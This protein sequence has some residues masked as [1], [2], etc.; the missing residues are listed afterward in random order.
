LCD[1]ISIGLTVAS[2]VATMAGQY[3]QGQAAYTQ[4]KY[5]QA[6]A[7]ANRHL[8]DQQAKDEIDRTK[9]TAAQR[10]RQASQLEG[11]QQAAMAA[12]GVDINFGS[13]LDVLKDS[14]MVAAEDVGNIYQQ[15]YQ[16]TNGYLIDAYNYRLKGMA[17]KSA[18]S[19][20][21]WATGIGMAGTALGGASQISKMKSGFG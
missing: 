2:T 8:A 20:A 13:P 5:E 19:S 11:Q 3:V 16:N 4:A 1:P 21:Q 17:A 6:G 10:Y 15:G 14:K 7:V 18:A 12:N 9:K